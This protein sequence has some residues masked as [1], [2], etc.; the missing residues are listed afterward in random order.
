MRLA[1]GPLQDVLAQLSRTQSA[2]IPE[3]VR[4][5]FRDVYDHALR[6]NESLD[7]LREMLT[8][9][10]SVNLS[11][12]TLEGTARLR[13]VIRAAIAIASQQAVEPSYIEALATSVPNS[14]ATWVWN[15]NS[16]CSVPCAI[17]GW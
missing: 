15:S 2:L 14:R 13:R 4:L 8:T 10:L 17:S 5:Y 16:T 12:V 6:V 3:E 7:T 11:L 1:V 9:A